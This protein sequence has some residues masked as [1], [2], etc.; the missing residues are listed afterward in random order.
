MYCKIPHPITGLFCLICCTAF[1]NTATSSLWAQQAQERVYAETQTSGGGLLS[2]VANAGNAVDRNKDTYSTM[3]ITVVGS[4]WQKLNF[5]SELPGPNDPVHIKIGTSAA[6]LG[7]GNSLSL[8]AYNGNDEV[9]EKYTLNTLIGLLAGEDQADIVLPAPGEPYDSVRVYYSGAALGGGIR[10]YEA[11]FNKPS[12]GIICNAASD[13]LWGSEASIVGGVNSVINPQYAVDG[14]D[15]S[16]AE[17]YSTAS[18]V[19]KMHLTTLYPITTMPGDSLRV[20]IQNPGGL[21]SLELLSKYLQIKAY[22]DNEE[23]T[24]PLDL[25][26]NVLSLKLLSG[27]SDTG[28]ITYPV[29]FP[30]NRIQVSIGDG[31]ATVLSALRVYEIHIIPQAP[32]ITAPNL[33]DDELHICYGDEV[34]LSVANPVAGSEYRWYTTET[35]TTPLYTGTSFNI[36]DL[37]TTT[38]YLAESRQGCT[39]ESARA[40]VRVYVSPNYGSPEISI[41]NE[42]D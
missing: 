14:D 26:A 24:E 12:T 1:F 38:Y 19:G 22:V 33:E 27:D 31:L 9:G 41:L 29:D 37:E 16:F 36:A 18:V 13:V 8:Q 17:L 34:T 42:N 25:D 23:E 15:T 32:K 3:S 5:T 20:V 21:L 30:F 10:I 39:D 28:A 7:L 6:L 2:M 4:V 40:S 11:Y 35:G